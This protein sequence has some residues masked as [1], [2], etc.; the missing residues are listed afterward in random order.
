MTDVARALGVHQT[1]VSLALRSHASIPP[2]TCERVREMA[3]KMGYRRNPLVSALISERKRGRMT[4]GTKLALLSMGGRAG[5]WRYNSPSYQRIHAHLIEHAGMLGYGLEEF[6]LNYAG[7]T[8]TQL[9][10]I[11]LH[12]GMR[13]I[14]V[15][16]IPTHCHALDFD[17]SDFAVVALRYTLKTPAVDHVSTDYCASM[18][19]AVERLRESGHRRIAFFS[20]ALT[21]ERVNHLSLGV[22]LAQRHFHP[23]ALPAPVILDKWEGPPLLREIERLKPDAV[24]TPITSHYKILRQCLQ[25]AGW[26]VPGQLSLV[27][28]DCYPQSQDS[29]ME[30]NLDEEARAAVG[31]VTSR[32]ERAEFGLPGQLQTILVKGTWRDGTTF[33]PRA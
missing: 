2:A 30:Q 11:L 9:R 17:F 23:R 14:I 16:P 31:L 32:V 1:T 27:N 26:K 12:R 29:G 8:P 19:A 21:D 18:E 7:H 4:H 10:R 13:G 33:R 20:E 5:S 25:S 6:P 22:Y 28:L 15:A 24:I 3:R